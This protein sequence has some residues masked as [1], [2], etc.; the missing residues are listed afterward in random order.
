MRC[1]VWK[2]AGC[3]LLG[4]CW[5]ARRVCR[6]GMGNCRPQ[7][8]P[9]PRPPLLPPLLTRLPACGAV[10]VASLK[11]ELATLRSEQDIREDEL[12]AQVGA[13]GG[14]GRG[15]ALSAACSP[16]SRR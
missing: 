1:A 7:G 3:C 9:H 11:L 12:L 4:G 16:S 10:Q 13:G 6:D 8:W 14:G 2:Q 15:G 5:A